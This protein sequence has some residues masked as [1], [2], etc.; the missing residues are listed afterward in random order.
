MIKKNKSKKTDAWDLSRIFATTSAYQAEFKDVQTKLPLLAQCQGQFT[1]SATSLLAGLKLLFSLTKKTGKLLAYSSLASDV[2]TTNQQLQAQAEQAHKLASDLAAAS[3]FVK[4]ALLKLGADKFAAFCQELP[5]LKDYQRYADRVFKEQGH[6]LDAASESLLAEAKQ[7]MDNSQQTYQVLANADLEFPYLQTDAGAEK[8]DE[9]NYNL[10][11]QDADRSVRQE[12]YTELYATYQQYEQTFAATLSGQVQAHNFL[13]QAHHYPNAWSAS[14]AQQEIPLAAYDNLFAVVHQHLD[15]FNR[16]L[17]LRKRVLKVDQLQMWDLYRPLL[18]LGPIS[19]SLSEA[20]TELKQALQ[21]L[22]PSYEK[23]LTYLFDHQLIDAA[24]KQG[25]VAGAYAAGSYETDSYILLNWDQSLDSVYALAHECG[26]AVHAMASKQT[27]NFVN[28]EPAIL[29]SEIAAMT[30]ENLLTNYFLDNLPV[31]Q[32]QALMLNYYLDSFKN[33]VFRQSQ[34]AEF[35]QK[36]HQ[37]AQTGQSLTADYLDQQYLQLNQQYYAAAV[38]D[39]AISHEWA[40]VPH[41]YYDFYLYQ[42]IIS[43]ALASDLA[44]ELRI[45]PQELVPKYQQFLQ[46]GSSLTPLAL[47]KQLGFDLT[48]TDYLER[49]LTTFDQRLSHLEQLI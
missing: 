20:E 18:Q 35:E 47:I 37:A 12:A 46:A 25:K 42:Y 5:Q 1:D 7:I 9:N 33:T 27:Q 3:S 4:P 39:E 13:A 24:P 31:A 2:D 10:L 6:F 40:R 44:Q 8:V 26:H 28:S 22:G 21:L 41:L 48:K 34:L 38:S 23:Q 36:I 15:L 30:N 16:Y 45:N 29:V 14:L 11:I 32:G 49:A 17:A 19:F 43:F